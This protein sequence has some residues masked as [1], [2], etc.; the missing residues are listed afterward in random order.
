MLCSASKM[1]VGERRRGFGERGQISGEVS[2]D[3][4][5]SL[6]WKVHGVALANI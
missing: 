4:L 1:G 3:G 2:E 6:L 5:Q